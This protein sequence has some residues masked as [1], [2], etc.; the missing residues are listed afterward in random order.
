MISV[1]IPCYNGE[2]YIDRCFS[3]LECQTIGIENLQIIVVD[4][5]SHDKSYSKLMRWKMKYPNSINIIRL[6]VNGLQG[7]ARNIALKY[8]TKKYIAYVDI[9]DYI[10]PETF[11]K[12]YKVA[13]K[14]G[15]EIV[16]YLFSMSG[17]IHPRV[18]EDQFFEI[19]TKQDRIDLFMN[20]SLV[21]GCWDKLFRR[22]FVEKYNLEFAEGVYDEESLFTTPAY[23]NFTKIY[24]LNEQLYVYYQ[25]PNGSTQ[26]CLLNKNHVKDNAKTWEK[27]YNKLK[28]NPNQELLEWFVAVNYFIRTILLSAARGTPCTISELHEMQNNMKSWFPNL[29][30]NQCFKYKAI[31]SEFLR[32]IDI[33]VSELNYY[34]YNEAL[35]IIIN[36]FPSDNNT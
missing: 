14:S 6:K 33:E 34:Q 28:D 2:K 7:H 36:N 8:C 17:K 22:D 11:E 1:I 9:D 32:L 35:K 21:R 24:F 3:H 30:D 31:Y 23:L 19:H 5:A 20:E 25:N 18:K 10:L 4:D 15:A 13:E 27:T 12:A 26:K 29:K 16:K